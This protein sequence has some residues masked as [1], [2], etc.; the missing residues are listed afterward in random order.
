MEEAGDGVFF[1]VGIKD[2]GAK[3]GLCSDVQG[4]SI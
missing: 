3:D 4:G 1:A 2:V